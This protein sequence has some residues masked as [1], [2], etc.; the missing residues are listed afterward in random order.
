MTVPARSV[1]PLQLHVDYMRYDAG[2]AP[3]SDV[4]AVIGFGAKAALPVDPRVVR[5]GLEPL[6]G[7][8]R[9]EVWRGSGSVKCKCD[10]AIRYAHDAH[11]LF[12]VIEVNEGDHRDIA[13]AARAAYATI[14]KFHAASPFAHVL[15]IWN[16]IDGINNGHGDGERYKQFC[17]GRAAALEGAALDAFP[18][19]TAIGRRDGERVL[20]V[21]WI[22]AKKPGR[23]IEN[24]RQVSAFNYPREYGPAS[25]SF[26]RAMVLEDRALLI[27]GTASVVGHASQHAGDVI[28]QLDETLANLDSLLASAVDAGSKLAREFGA[29]SVLK[30]YVRD[31]EAAARVEA[32]L[33]EKLPAQ[34]PYL[35]LTG[36]ICR[37]DL[38]VEVDVTHLA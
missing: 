23:A 3:G 16:Y 26:S 28:A 17:V 18:A 33:R 36:D 13:Q 11:L 37:A 35:I 5:V 34:T 22:A 24:P 20:Q 10:G 15:R 30:V 32:R 38:Q 2:L 14:R 1:R 12:G 19:A 25:P 29:H 21:Y 6:S 4:L 7:A 31:P 27:S 9:V 8:G